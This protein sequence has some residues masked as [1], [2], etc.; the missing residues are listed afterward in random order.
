MERCRNKN[1]R[2]TVATSTSEAGN[3]LR[4]LGVYLGMQESKGVGNV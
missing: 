3:I 1:S 4:G 2:I